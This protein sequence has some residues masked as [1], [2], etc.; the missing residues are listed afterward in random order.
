MT[1][2][3][4]GVI[5]SVDTFLKTFEDMEATIQFNNK[6]YTPMTANATTIRGNSTKIS[7][8]LIKIII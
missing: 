1:Q 2:K 8:P 6:Q 7:I 4:L 3:I 5:L